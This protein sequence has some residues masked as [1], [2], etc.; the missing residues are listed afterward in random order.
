MTPHWKNDILL[1]AFLRQP[2]IVTAHHHDAAHGME[3][4]AEIADRVNSLGAVTWSDPQAIL[5][6]NYLQRTEGARLRVKMYSRCVRIAVPPGVRHLSV[7]RPWIAPDLMERMFVTSQSVTRTLESPGPVTEN[8]A[9]GDGD[10]V[11]LSSEVANPLLCSRVNR[12]RVRARVIA[13][14]ILMEARDR[15]SPVLPF[16]HHARRNGKNSLQYASSRIR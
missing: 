16:V 13:R 15:L 10:A 3:V 6:T 9:L 5:R 1:A 11:E 7:E 12:P 4:L 2:I 14:K 8:I